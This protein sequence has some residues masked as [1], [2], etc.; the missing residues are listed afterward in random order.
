MNITVDIV[1]ATGYTGQ[2]LIGI[3][4]RHPNVRIGRLYST[5]DEPK[6]LSELL[7]RFNNK[8][9][10]VCQKLDKKALAS[11]DADL[12]FLAMPHTYSMAIVP[13][14][15]KAGKRVIDLGA[16]FRIKDAR[17]YEEYYDVKHTDRGLLNQAV[18]GLPEMNRQKIKK[19]KLI[20]NPGCYPT[21]AILG[22]SP[23]LRAGC[24]GL[25]SIIIDAKSGTSGAGKK[26]VKDFLFTEVDEDFRA[27]KI[28]RHQH[29]PEIKQEL[30]RQADKEI[31]ITFVPHL[32]PLKRGIL[33]TIYVKSNASRKPDTQDIISLYKRFYQNEPFVRIREEGH[34]PTLKDVVGTNYCDI[35][36]SV[37]GK[38]IIIIAV[39]DN[40]L[41]GA[42]GQAVQNMNIMFRF[43]EE[44]ALI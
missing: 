23:L 35:G 7:P 41:K 31:Q 20:A 12:V 6:K 14:L 25:D 11:S 42:S 28:N 21:A 17:V 33:E 34:F 8:T 29:M 5:T 22:L 40:L 15:L 4:L 1:G 32:L 26:A 30:S 44:A 43:P 27:Y 2:E 36:I 37:S 3:L 18:Y 16:D 24:V 19:A 9:D 38:D 10:L 13:E 39:I